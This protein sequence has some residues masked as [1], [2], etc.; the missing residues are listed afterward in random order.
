MSESLH[1]RMEHAQYMGPT[2]SD[3]YNE[4]VERAYKD[5]VMLLNKVGLADEDA[6]NRFSN[7]VK[8]HFSLMKTMTDLQSRLTALEDITISSQP[9]K[10][11]T[12][13]NNFYDDTDNFNDTEFEISSSQK[14]SIDS[15]HGVMTL[16]KIFSSSSSKIG[17]K[18]SYGNFVLPA[19]F[20][21]SASGITSTADS[22]SSLISSSNLNNSVIDEPGK[23][24]ERNVIVNSPNENGAEVNFY[25]RIPTDIS[26][27][28]NANAIV[29]H[30]YPMMGV[31]LLGVFTSSQEMINLNSNDSYWP[32]NADN[33]YQDNLDAVGWIAPGSWTGDSIASCG[34]KI[35]H[36]D[37][38]K[39]NAVRIRLKQSDYFFESD[40]FIYSYGLSFFDLRYDKFLSTGKIIL[41]MDAPTGQTISSIDNV[42]PSIF[43]VSEAELPYVFS[44]RVIWETA[45][46]G[47]Y[48]LDPVAFSDKVW[49]EVE[50][51]ETIG[52]GTPS[53]SGL[54]VEYS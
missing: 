48:S 7:L 53:L 22:T 18:D 39:V 10:L 51:D 13:F 41:R 33:Y 46:S 54:K 16:P 1:S 26:P 23:V 49:I 24:W 21:A 14:C 40:K 32:V 3:N 2:T 43:N 45:T 36:F 37:P 47:V 50:L 15:R 44:Y 42:T 25:A 31:E 28:V 12:F 38:K 19:S 30:P 17:Y 4:R 8:N 6:K 29:I 11:I 34:P 52:K 20:E 27:N 35:F 9:Y 5:L